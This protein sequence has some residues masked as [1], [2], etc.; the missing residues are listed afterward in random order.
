MDYKQVSG[1]L[2]ISHHYYSGNVRPYKTKS[3][4]RE[5]SARNY[6]GLYEILGVK[7]KIKTVKNYTYKLLYS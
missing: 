2:T 3:T 5:N 1:L 7:W 4:Y 6:F